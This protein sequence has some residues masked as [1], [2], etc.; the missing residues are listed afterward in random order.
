MAKLKK[1]GKEMKFRFDVNDEEVFVFVTRPDPGVQKAFLKGRFDTSKRGRLK[2]HSVSAAEEFV[3][4]I[5]LRT[6]NLEADGP[7]GTEVPM[8]S[9][10]NWKELIPLEWKISI[11]GHFSDAEGEL[12]NG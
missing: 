3:D 7:D 1:P 6:E 2:D 5:L 11:A 12:V 8:D 9:L 10:P 4:K